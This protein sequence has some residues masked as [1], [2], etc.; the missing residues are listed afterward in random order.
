MPDA[1]RFPS[2]QEYAAETAR[3]RAGE[4]VD[5]DAEQAAMQVAYGNRV[6]LDFN[7]HCL[8]LTVFE[9]LYRWHSHPDSD[10]LFL[11]MAGELEIEFEDRP[12]VSLLPGQCF[13]VPAGT[14]HRTR[15]IGRTVN[16]TCEK[17]G[18]Q[19]VFKDEAG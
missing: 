16:L 13:V 3:H 8:R 18:A 15:G 2:A 5:L 1:R 14:V 6:M 11:V 12:R 9:G 19:T 10:E 17:R 4:R 7:D